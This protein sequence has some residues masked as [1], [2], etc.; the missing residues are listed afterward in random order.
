MNP[1]IPKSVGIIA[2]LEKPGARERSLELLTLLAEHQI[3]VGLETS[4]AKLLGREAEGLELKVLAPRMDMLVVLGGD[5]TILRTVRE[6]GAAET[7]VLGINLGSLGF[8]TSVRSEELGAAAHDILH[9]ASAISERQTL[10]ATVW[11]AGK[12]LE[13]HGALNEAVVSR[14]AVSRTVRL[15]ISIDGEWLT[16]YVCD[17]MI[18]ATAT[19]STA[20]SLSAGG[21]ILLPTA[22]ARILTPICPHA[23]SNR[24]I[25]VGEQSVVRCRLAGGTGELLLTVDGQV[26]LGLQ[27]G[28]EVEVKRSPRTVHL[29]TPKGHE[30]FKVVREKL[31]WSGANV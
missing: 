11:R 25:I 27:V 26:H 13:S 22:R 24:S 19:G 5:G 6:M 17:G 2:N 30:Y 14:G 29:V 12:E 21:P 8:L 3:Q 23:L 16:E 18:F 9:G 28:D 4:L 1:V 20:Y 10:Q 7:P 15:S 31:K